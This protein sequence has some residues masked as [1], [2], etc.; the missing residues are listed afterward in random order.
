M[1]TTGFAGRVG[2]RLG[3]QPQNIK[4]Q[5][6]YAAL[7]RGAL[8]A[9]D[10]YSPVDDLKQN[11]QRVAPYSYFPSW[12]EGGVQFGLYVN[13]KA[14]D[15]LPA[16]FKLILEMACAQAHSQMQARYDARNPQALRSMLASGARLNRFP[17]EVMNAAF[18]AANEHY[19]EL[20]A[21]N[22]NWR[23]VFEDWSKFRSDGFAW[24]R[25]ADG[26]FEQTMQAM[27]L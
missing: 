7:E 9:A 22:P 20:S 27:R 17:L 26:A 21:N 18:K 4:V 19:A 8:D 6:V 24:S 15:A 10:W 1:R 23:R 12:W 5:D 14:Y 13:A 16:E 2:L 25:V 11:F 3:I